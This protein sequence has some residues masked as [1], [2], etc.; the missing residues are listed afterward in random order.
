M[1]RRLH[2]GQPACTCGDPKC[3]QLDYE[4][5]GM[6]T[7]LLSLGL[8]LAAAVGMLAYTAANRL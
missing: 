8:V 1:A 7:W 4:V 6:P 5:L 3:Q 2:W